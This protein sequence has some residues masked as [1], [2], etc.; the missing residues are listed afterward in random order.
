MDE[1]DRLGLCIGDEVI[2][3]RA[4]EVIPKIV[5]VFKHKGGLKVQMIPSCPDC[6]GEIVKLAG[7]VAH[8]CISFLYLLAVTYFLV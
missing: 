6:G 2:V 3:I 5:C 1:I 7:E 8:R 4:G